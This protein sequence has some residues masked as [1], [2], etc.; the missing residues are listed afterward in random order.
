MWRTALVALTAALLLGCATKKIALD[1]LRSPEKVAFVLLPSDVLSVSFPLH[2]ELNVAQPV[3]PD[4]RVAFDF[5]GEIQAEGRTP[6]EI[7][8][9]LVCLYTPLLKKVEVTVVVSGVDGHRVYVG[10]EVVNPGLVAMSAPMTVMEAIVQV[11]G[12]IRQS[13]R[14]SEVIV[15][16]RIEGK[17]HAMTVD[18]K[19]ALRESETDALYLQPFDIVFVPPTK[20]DKVGQWVDQH[21]NRL[22]PENVIF[23]FD[24]SLDREDRQTTNQQTLQF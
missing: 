23:T 6:E 9:E 4:G 17:Q 19:K 16:R 18:V 8:Q 13:A 10:G 21:I 24:K 15:V 5:V 7:R 3:R 14:K 2:P 22:I 20:I 11:G 12:F 1:P